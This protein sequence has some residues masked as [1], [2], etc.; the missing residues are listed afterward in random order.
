MR[1]SSKIHL[2]YNDQ[3]TTILQVK[4]ERNLKKRRALSS[5][6]LLVT[7]EHY[8]GIILTSGLSKRC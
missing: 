6:L 3:I 7:G 1:I 2:C 4:K 5:V 8:S